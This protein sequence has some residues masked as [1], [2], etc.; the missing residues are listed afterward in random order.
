MPTNKHAIIRY[1]A[2]DKCF[3]N[4]NRRYYIDD[5]IDAC[6]DAI[7]N[8]TGSIDGVKRRQIF[9]DIAFMES[10]EGWNIPLD[11]IKDGRRVYYRYEDKGFSINKK[12]ITDNEAQQLQETLL[13]L[14]RFKGIAQ[15]EWL[16]QFLSGIEDK[17][18][19]RGSTKSHIGFEQNIDLERISSLSVLFEHIINQDPLEIEYQ[20]FSKPKI[21]IRLH[22]YYLKQYNT[23]WF[24]LGLN[25]D[26][27]NIG[28][29]PLDRILSFQKASFP[30]KPNNAIDFDE[31]FDDVIGVTL[32]T[33]GKLEKIVLKF[34]KE[35]FPYITSK[36]LHLSQ[37]IKSVDDC[38]VEIEVIPNSELETLIMSFGWQVEVLSPEYL[39]E[40]IT[41]NIEKL[42]TLY[43]C[44]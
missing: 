20:P 27:G 29:Y 13:M 1:Q 2:L 18:N 16:E 35:R 24:L 40:R 36:P 28:N 7:Y 34:A 37:K 4:F 30:F 32:P 42:N 44:K 3:A 15:F 31:Y 39:R 11:K 9:L 12:P 22:P 43:L 17:F 38:I 19:L 33:N 5:L 6:N 23:R 26:Y 21:K 14:S 25:D 10:N 8:F 41:L